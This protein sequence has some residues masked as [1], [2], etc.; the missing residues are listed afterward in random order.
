MMSGPVNIEQLTK[1]IR[2]VQL[3]SDDSVLK[4]KDPRE[5]AT[6]VLSHFGYSTHIVDNSKTMDPSDRTYLYN[7]ESHRLL[8]RERD[9]MFIKSKQYWTTDWWVI[10]ENMI[11]KLACKDDSVFKKEDDVETLYQNLF[12]EMN[13]HDPEA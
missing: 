7:L 11:K 8:S 3:H 10:N 13:A 4:E 9:M 1:A 12:A 5:V 2:Y 6:I